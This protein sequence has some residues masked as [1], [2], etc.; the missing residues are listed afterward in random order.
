MRDIVFVHPLIT[1]VAG[2]GFVCKICPENFSSEINSLKVQVQY[3]VG[4]PFPMD[5]LF[6]LMAKIYIGS[7]KKNC[8]FYVFFVFLG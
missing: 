6:G 8:W 5:G 2:G 1:R 4:Y 7:Y 3:L